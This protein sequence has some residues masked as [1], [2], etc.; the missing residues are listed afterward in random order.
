MI[1]NESAA[2]SVTSAVDHAA[3]CTHELIVSLAGRNEVS[4]SY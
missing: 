4:C 1:N 3:E 2:L